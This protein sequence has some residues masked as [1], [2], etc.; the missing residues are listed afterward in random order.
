VLVCIISFCG[1]L[2]VVVRGSNVDQKCYSTLHQKF[3]IFTMSRD[4]EGQ[5]Q[6]VEEQE[7][8]TEEEQEVEEQEQE[9]EEDQEQEQDSDWEEESPLAVPLEFKRPGKKF[10]KHMVHS[11][12]EVEDEKDFTNILRIE[13]IQ[14]SAIQTI[15]SVTKRF[16]H[17][18]FVWQKQFPKHDGMNQKVSGVFFCRTHF[19]YRSYI[20]TSRHSK[21]RSVHQQLS[22]I[23]G[24]LK[25]TPST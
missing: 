23:Y 1:G 7:Q 9:T 22:T 13:G 19:Q 12:M 8:E 6:E 11:R 10:L 20:N 17:F 5:E 3:I 25:N 16:L 14:P 21:T 2:C 18:K 15:V 4:F 24:P